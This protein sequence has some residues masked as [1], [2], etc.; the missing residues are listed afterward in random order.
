MF[1]RPTLIFA[2]LIPNAA[3]ADCTIPAYVRSEAPGAPVILSA[4]DA[5]AEQVGV[6]PMV[7]DSERGMMGGHALITDIRD[8]YAAVTQVAGWDNPALTAPDGW[9]SAADL[10][11]VAQ[12]QKGFAAPDAASQVLWQGQ[13]WIYPDMIAMLEAC[14]GEWVALRLL[15]APPADPI[16]VRGICAGQETTCDGVTG[17][18]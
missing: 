3:M 8:G 10:V 14:D 15:D 4:P 13:D 17:D 2:L 9:V 5:G 18:N 7:N 16:W 1:L 11:F 6:M 12:T